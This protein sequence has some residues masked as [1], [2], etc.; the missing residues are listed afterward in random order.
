MRRPELTRRRRAVSA[1]AAVAL[2]VV[3]VGCSGSS[4]SDADDAVPGTIDDDIAPSTSAPSSTPTTTAG[5]AVDETDAPSPWTV[6]VDV[7]LTDSADA[8]S[9]QASLA[10]EFDPSAD[11]TFD[12]F[13]ELASC[14]GWRSSVTAYSLLVQTDGPVGLFSLSVAE[15]VTGAGTYDALVR[16]ERD[17]GGLDLVGTATLDDAMQ[18]GEFVAFGPAGEV[19]EGTFSC[20]GTDPP[21]SLALGDPADDRVDTVEV[22]ALMRRDGRVVIVGLATEAPDG[23]VC[24]VVDGRATVLVEGGAEIGSMTAFDLAADP[25]MLRVVVGGTAFEFEALELLDVVVDD[26]ARASGT[27]G[28]DADG[29]EIDGAFR[30]T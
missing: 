15:A 20:Q 2:A 24:E 1:V 27:F 13:T 28:A 17:R 18:S 8:S 29:V 22:T 12:P 19:A 25:A 11:A 9:D 16:V 4:E 21:E 10:R 6:L 26:S 5:S 30:C 14:S 7:E 3:P 23:A